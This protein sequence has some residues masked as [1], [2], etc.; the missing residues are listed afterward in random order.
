MQKPQECDKIK[1]NLRRFQCPA[2]NKQ[3]IL[4]LLPSTV[5]KELPWKCKRCGQEYIVNI[6][7]EPEP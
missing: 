7:S 4:F 5:V 1:T 3:T 2:C 6:S